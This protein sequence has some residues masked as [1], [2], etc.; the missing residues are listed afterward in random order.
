MWLSLCPTP[1]TSETLPALTDPPRPHHA[2][3][4]VT[5]SQPKAA[6]QPVHEGP[7]SLFQC[8]LP[9]LSGLGEGFSVTQSPLVSTD[10]TA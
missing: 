1:A 4:N 10:D 9:G 8:P 3:A 6:R 5:N 2:Q 7:C